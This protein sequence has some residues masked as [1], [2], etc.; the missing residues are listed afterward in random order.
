MSDR[1]GTQ[2]LILYKI[3]GGL[4]RK[5]SWRWTGRAVKSGLKMLRP[6]PPSASII[7]VVLLNG[8]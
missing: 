4:C 8:N 5:A 7:T 2:H 1:G 6:L 3:N